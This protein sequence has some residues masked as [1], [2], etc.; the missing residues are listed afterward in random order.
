[1]TLPRLDLIL[2]HDA[3]AREPPLPE[4]RVDAADLR[5][6]TRHPLRTERGV[7]VRTEPRVTVRAKCVAAELPGERDG[8]QPQQLQPDG[9]ADRR[10]ILQR[11]DR[12][13]RPARF[14]KLKVF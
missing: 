2:G 12:E 7:A 6:P 8:A 11:N 1:M 4:Q 13:S 3:L 14:E 10:S 5:R 9:P